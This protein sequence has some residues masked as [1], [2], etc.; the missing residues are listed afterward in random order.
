[1]FIGTFTDRK[2]FPELIPAIQDFKIVCHIGLGSYACLQENR[3]FFPLLNGIRIRLG[4]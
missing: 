4:P 3:S 1:M 2:A